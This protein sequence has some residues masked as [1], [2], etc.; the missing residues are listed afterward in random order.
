MR[1]LKKGSVAIILFGALIAN[2]QKKAVNFQ[3][4]YRQSY[5]G[6]AR[7]SDEI[8]ADLNKPTPYRFQTIIFVS[9]KG[10]ADSIKT[11]E[12]GDIK[13]KLRVGKYKVYEAWRYYKKTPAGFSREDFDLVCL[14][15]EWKKEVKEIIVTTKDIKVIDK[16]EIIYSCPWN[17]SCI[18]DSR[19][20]PAAE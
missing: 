13:I 7:P 8:M 1:I 16:N 10:K 3:I 17:V 11:T 12:N 5:C 15:A 2:S 18:L 9:S 20:P 6:G 4:N 14:Q 19:R